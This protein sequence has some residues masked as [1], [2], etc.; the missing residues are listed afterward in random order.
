MKKIIS[1]LFL[2]GILLTTGFAAH[3]D[4][5]SNN[6]DLIFTVMRKGDEI[7]THSIKFDKKENQLH[8]TIKTNVVVTLPL[9]HI[10]VYKFEH[11][12]EETWNGNK[13]NSLI[14][15]TN[16]DG[17]K[18]RL[19][20]TKTSE[21]LKII[22]DDV[23][24]QSPDTIIPASLWNKQI[25]NSGKILNTL[26]GHEMLIAVTSLGSEEINVSGKALTAKHYQITGD[27]NREVWYD[28]NDRLVSVRF[29]GDDGSEIHYILN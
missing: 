10:P 17:A 1:S 22:G 14:S 16:D 3:A 2:V 27:L 8:V 28:D 21:T 6:G 5:K 4:W 13:L 15:V 25:L 23:N 19:N 18:H 7:G 26:D 20:V 9:I 24:M 11:S 12:G 29:N